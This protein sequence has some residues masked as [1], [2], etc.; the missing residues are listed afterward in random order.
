MDN[1]DDYE[2][3]ITFE[4]AVELKRE[5]G[6][7][8]GVTERV[9]EHC[10]YT[11]SI[12]NGHTLKGLV[13]G[14]QIKFK[15]SPDNHALDITPATWLIRY[16]RDSKGEGHVYSERKRKVNNVDEL[17]GPVRRDDMRYLINMGYFVRNIS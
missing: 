8:R 10:T 6:L 3:P 7:K 17:L 4:D 9:H 14:K 2:H 12:G 5:L 13:Q 15:V 16:G 1:I 11:F